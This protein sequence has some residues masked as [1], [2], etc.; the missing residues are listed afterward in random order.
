MAH[1]RMENRSLHRMWALRVRREMLMWLSKSQAE[2]N[3]SNSYV[4]QMD[5]R[6]KRIEKENYDILAV[7]QKSVKTLEEQ[8]R[9]LKEQQHKILFGNRD[10]DDEEI[11]DTSNPLESTNQMEMTL[12]SEMGFSKGAINKES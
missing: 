11:P 5:D 7:V 3:S 1:M 9:D 8:F 10:N 6:A 12:K 4:L 2:I